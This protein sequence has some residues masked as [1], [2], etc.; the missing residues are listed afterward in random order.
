MQVLL[1]V[2]DGKQRGRVVPLGPGQHLFGRDCGCS[3]RLVSELVSPQHCLLTVEAD[4]VRLRDLGSA[5]GTLVNGR[6]V[7]GEA[8]LRDGD[9]IVIS[10]LDFRVRFDLWAGGHGEDDGFDTVSEIC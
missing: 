2:T 10:P 3:V 5:H 1:Q 7:R 6:P 9:S 4:G 8:E